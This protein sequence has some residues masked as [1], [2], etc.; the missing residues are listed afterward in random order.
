MQQY[1]RIVLM[2]AR[3]I[4]RREKNRGRLIDLSSLCQM[5]AF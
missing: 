3:L 2:S 4:D 1:S 5:N